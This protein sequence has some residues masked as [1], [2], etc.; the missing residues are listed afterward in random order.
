MLKRLALPRSILA[1][2]SSIADRVTDA[3]I[4]KSKLAKKYDTQQRPKIAGGGIPSKSLKL[5]LILPW[6]PSLLPGSAVRRGDTGPALWLSRV[7]GGRN[8]M[9]G[10]LADESEVWE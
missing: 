3:S 5:L 2:C 4:L 7:F 9:A 1:N 8:T 6:V 10:E